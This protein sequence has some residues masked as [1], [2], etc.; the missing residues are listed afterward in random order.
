MIAK[1]I[2]FWSLLALS[3]FAFALAAQMRV[4]VATVLRRALAAKF[5]GESASPDYRKAV[6]DAVNGE[7]QS[8]EAQH[9]C[10]TYPRPLSHIR[11]ARRASILALPAIALILLAGRFAL[12]VI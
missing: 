1:T 6:V 10:E 7:P 11:L 3:G 9:L 4:L 5:G 12:G 8:K 2:L